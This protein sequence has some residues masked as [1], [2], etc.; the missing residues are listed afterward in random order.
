M[1]EMRQII[2]RPLRRVKKT[3]K[4]VVASYMQWNKVRCGNYSKFNLIVK[5]DYEQM[6]KSDLVYN[7]KGEQ[8]YHFGYN[9]W[10]VHEHYGSC[11]ADGF[12]WD[13]MRS[14]YKDFILVSEDNGSLYK[15]YHI[16]GADCVGTP[17]F[18]HYY[19]DRVV[20]D[21]VWDY[22]GADAFE[23]VTVGYVI[24]WLGWFLYQLENSYLKIGK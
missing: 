22:Y 14:K 9:P 15:S 17:T 3:G 2:F 13:E 5:N 19:E 20:G 7:H 12:D 21:D 18:T 1:N 24:T 6:N 4:V 11:I 16:R 23:P 8:L 10:D